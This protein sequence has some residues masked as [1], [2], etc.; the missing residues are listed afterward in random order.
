LRR[1][2]NCSRW[3]LDADT[4]ESHPPARK[5]MVSRVIDLPVFHNRS[6]PN[7]N[8]KGQLVEV[9]AD[10]GLS[11]RLPIVR[12]LFSMNLFLALSL[13]ATVYLMG[14]AELHGRAS[15][16]DAQQAGGPCG[17]GQATSECSTSARRPARR[18]FSTQEVERR[19]NAPRERG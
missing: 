12:S 4:S 3:R 5:V 11:R 19:K 15:H 18:R 14:V 16:Q 7:G 17:P 6:N 9:R 8:S 1:D 2:P 10:R 13:L